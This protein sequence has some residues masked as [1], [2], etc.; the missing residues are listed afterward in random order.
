MAVGKNKRSAKK[1][2]LKK[3]IVDPFVKKDWYDVKAPGQFTVRLAGKIPVNK[4]AGTRIA[5]DALKGRIMEV[6]LADLQRNEGDAH[7]KIK[8]RIEDVQGSQVLTNFHGMDLTTDK[9]RSLVKK[10]Q[11]LIESTVTTKTADGYLIRLFAIGFTKRRPNQ[12]RKTSYAQ[13]SQVRAIRKVMTDILTREANTNELKD[14]VAK[15][16][17]EILGTQIEKEAQKIYPLQNVFVRKVKVLKTPR[18][19]PAKLAEIH[20]GGAAA[21]PVV[22]QPAPAAEDTGAQV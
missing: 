13:S 3:K 12:I 4:T 2:G 11:T 21:A 7:R 5:S 8:L 9:Y 18:F 17:P 22:A 6:S 16:I 1:K 14:L 20:E 10:W 19:D 15:F